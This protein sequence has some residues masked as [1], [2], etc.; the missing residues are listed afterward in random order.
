MYVISKVKKSMIENQHID[1]LGF[2]YDPADPSVIILGIPKE[3]IRDV[4]E[5]PEGFWTHDVSNPIPLEEINPEAGRLLAWLCHE[6]GKL[7]EKKRNPLASVRIHHGRVDIQQVEAPVSV[8]EK[9]GRNDPCPC[10]SN[11][12]YKRCCGK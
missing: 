3:T 9:V 5:H 4:K 2:P 7:K 11:L 6:N 1:D 8:S 10:G 12:K